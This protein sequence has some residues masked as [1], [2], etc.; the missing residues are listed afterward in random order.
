M[1]SGI[2]K[3]WEA[4]LTFLPEYKARKLVNIVIANT[5]SIEAPANIKVGMLLLVPIFL[6]IRLII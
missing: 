6:S 3:S 4:I 5:S 2:C 1:E